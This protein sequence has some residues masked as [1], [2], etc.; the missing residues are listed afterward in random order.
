[1]PELS[2]K[3]MG[4]HLDN[5]IIVSSSGLVKDIDGVRLCADAGAGAIVLKSLFEE[6]IEVE[7]KKQMEKHSWLYTNNDAF[8]YVREL[9]MGVGSSEYLDLIREAKRSV[10]IP[11]IASLNCIS[12]TWWTSYA[13]QIEI[14]GADALELNITLLPSLLNRKSEEIEDLYFSIFE[15]IKS[16]V[17]I[18]IAVKLPPYFSSL[19]HTAHEFARRGAKAIVLFNRAYQFD[20]DIDKLEPTP[21]YHLS[22]TEEV[23]LSLRWVALLSGRVGCDIASSTGVHDSK[24]VI[25]QLLAGASAVQICS[26]IY[27]NGL[28]Q[29]AKTLKGLND[30]MKAK[31][32]NYLHQFQGKLAQMNSKNPELYERLQY[33]KIFS[34]I[35][36]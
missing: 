20:I 29:I 35:V 10:H 28:E 18:P 25:K 13:K 32:F 7:S 9:R 6:Q 23:T 4:L 27:I 14:S 12:P 3:Y 30:W 22:S 11:I 33:I 36:E 17:N 8:N 34:G 2:T 24:G 15:D 21:G 31:R 19:A 1:M 5:P 26:T 16:K